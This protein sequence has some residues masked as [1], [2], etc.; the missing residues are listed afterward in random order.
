M[1]PLVFQ[2]KCCVICGM[3]LLSGQWIRP[4]ENAKEELKPLTPSSNKAPF[5]S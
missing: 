5:A 3:E 2:K 4:S 1:V